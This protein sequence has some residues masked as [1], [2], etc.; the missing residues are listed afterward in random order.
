MRCSPLFLFKLYH[1]SILSVDFIVDIKEQI[2]RQIGITR[3]KQKIIFHGK[4]L[5]DLQTVG[6][7][8]L[9]NGSSVHMVS[10]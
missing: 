3:D 8:K 4:V 1:Y 6:F 10:R 5:N 7:Y 9:E 2:R